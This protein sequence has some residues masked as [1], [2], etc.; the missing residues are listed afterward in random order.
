MLY[1]KTSLTLASVKYLTDCILIMLFVFLGRM[2]VENVNG[3]INN[4]VSSFLRPVINLFSDIVCSYAFTVVSTI[5]AFIRHFGLPPL[6][7]SRP[8]FI[9]FIVTN[10][11]IYFCFFYCHFYFFLYYKPR[12]LVSLLFFFHIL[13]FLRFF[14]HHMFFLPLF[15]S[16]I[17]RFIFILFLFHSFLCFV[18]SSFRSFSF[19]L[20]FNSPSIVS[21]ILF[22]F[23]L[24]FS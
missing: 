18:S 12:F 15:L 11:F 13:S 21:F 14:F 10:S 17:F 7:T 1:L 8:C 9:Y 20:S 23:S 16:I 3:K 5:T 22:S 2:I 4:S 19:F 24:S 6:A